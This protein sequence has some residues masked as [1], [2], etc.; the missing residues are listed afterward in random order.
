MPKV[1]CGIVMLGVVAG[2]VAGATTLAAVDA[3]MVFCHDPLV[4]AVFVV[5]VGGS[6]WKV[7]LQMGF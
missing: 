2:A 6:V 4:A 3:M 5:F 1:G 7:L